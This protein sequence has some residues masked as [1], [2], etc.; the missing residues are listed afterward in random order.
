MATPYVDEIVIRTGGV[1]LKGNFEYE[2]VL[3]EKELL[4]A[5]SS[6][7]EGKG[8]SFTMQSLDD[9]EGE[10]DEDTDDLIKTSFIR[11]VSADSSRKTIGYYFAVMSSRLNLSASMDLTPTFF[12]VNEEY[13][14]MRKQTADE[15]D[16]CAG[17]KFSNEFTLTACGGLLHGRYLTIQLPSETAFRNWHTA[18]RSALAEL[19]LLSA[20]GV[21]DAQVS[22]KV[23]QRLDCEKLMDALQACKL[24]VSQE[25]P[26]YVRAQ[27]LW[28]SKTT[29][30]D[31]LTRAMAVCAII[32]DG[33]EA[34]GCGLERDR[35]SSLL[36]SFEPSFR[37]V[38]A[39]LSL[40]MRRRR[41][42]EEVEEREGGRG[43]TSE[44]AETGATAK[45]E[46]EPYLV[47]SGSASG[48][49]TSLMFALS[50]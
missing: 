49:S 13:S 34:G 40:S 7:A 31:F 22:S 41:E 18:V 43:S 42:R 2:Q 19:K 32:N 26:L 8:S 46:K 39:S 29:L 44:R 35:I 45:T 15:A 6:R 10:D 25:N 30:Q 5:T 48:E 17:S 24:L 21:A 16:F 47:S 38:R 20:L 11:R 33:A 1:G 3:N 50:S 36:S 37:M 9:Y 4:L 12:E 28:L 27:A 14:P 23:G